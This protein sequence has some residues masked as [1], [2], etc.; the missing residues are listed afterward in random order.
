MKFYVGGKEIEIVSVNGD[1]GEDISIDTLPDRSKI[2][3]KEDLENFFEFN[4]NQIQKIQVTINST[5]FYT[6]FIKDNRS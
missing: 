3:T 5:M 6:W 4:Y 1:K 2:I